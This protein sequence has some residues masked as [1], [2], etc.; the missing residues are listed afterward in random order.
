MQSGKF[1]FQKNA[2]DHV[3][4]LEEEWKIS[5]IKRDTDFQE[6]QRINPNSEETF[7]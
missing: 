7:I 6:W 2:N 1:P 4:A 5:L 3:K